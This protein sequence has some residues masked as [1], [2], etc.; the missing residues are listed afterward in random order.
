MV[1][2]VEI[3]CEA[4]PIN[5]N[6]TAPELYSNCFN[7]LKDKDIFNNFFASSIVITSSSITNVGLFVS[8]FEVDSASSVLSVE[9]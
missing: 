9:G 2:P 4:K 3:C 8:S 1:C 6:E 7:C 5:M